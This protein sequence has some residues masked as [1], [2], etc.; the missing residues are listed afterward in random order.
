MN[1]N[2]ITV[3]C[4]SKTN[5]FIM[6]ALGA[7]EIL[8]T[9]PTPTTTTTTTTV[10][11]VEEPAKKRGRRKK[12]VTEKE[13]KKTSTN[14]SKKEGKESKLVQINQSLPPKTKNLILNLL[15][16]LQDIDNYIR[17][18]AWKSDEYA[19]DPKIPID[20]LPYSSNSNQE[21]HV[22]GD[23]D[24]ASSPNDFTDVLPSTNTNVSG[25]PYINTN[26]MNAMKSLICA[27]CEKEM[28]L[29]QNPSSLMVKNQNTK[30]DLNDKDI[31]KVK[32]LKIQFYKQIIPEKKVD[33]FWCTCPYD[34]DSFH[35]LQHGSEGNII[36]HG[37]YCSPSCAVA[38]LFKHMHWDDSAVLE[39]YQLMNHYYSD[40]SKPV[41]KHDNIKPA[42]SPYYT[43]DKYY[44]TLTIQEYRKLSN[45]NYMLLCLEKPVSRVLPEIHEDNDK[46]MTSQSIR[47][48][49]KVKKQSEK[50]TSTNRNDILKSN[51]GV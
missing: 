6:S 47:G 4:S 2:K 8:T 19:Y 7:P 13:A 35:I 14:Q 3:Y 46:M 24:D 30:E 26:N 49:Y 41:S 11:T 17:N 25:A 31:Q 34:N 12:I 44:G 16:S 29:H 20:I 1:L 45:S 37:S 51:F 5:Y 32:E 36:A 33:C 21:Y 15:C 10:T 22:L 48:N 39:S 40:P 27:K 23:S 9:T 43:L 18:Q 50:N 42:C 38:Y 28:N